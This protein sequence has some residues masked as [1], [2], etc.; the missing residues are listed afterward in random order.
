[1]AADEFYVVHVGAGAGL[2][3][4]GYRPGVAGAG[5]QADA[6]NDIVTAAGRLDHWLRAAEAAECGRIVGDEQLGGDG[7]KADE[8]A[9][10]FEVQWSGKAVP[11]LW[12]IEYGVAI[13]GGLDGFGIIGNRVALGAEGLYISPLAHVRQG[14][15][16]GGDRTGEGGQRHDVA[17]GGIGW[18]R[19]PAGE[20]QSGGQSFNQVHGRARRY[21]FSADTTDGEYGGIAADDVAEIDL[22][23]GVV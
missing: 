18:I 19:V 20:L 23:D 14:G 12:E 11:A 1:M 17:G 8:H 7:R 22:V 15:D 2:P 9:V 21:L 5:R 6:G 13:D 3:F 4:A 10:R 16:I